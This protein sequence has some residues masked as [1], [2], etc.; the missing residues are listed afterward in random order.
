MATG[1][2]T[3]KENREREREKRRERKRE[4]GG[5]RYPNTVHGVGERVQ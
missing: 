2:K 3:D 5:K 1:R 4:M